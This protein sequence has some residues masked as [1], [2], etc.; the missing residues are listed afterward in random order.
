[1]LAGGARRQRGGE[2]ASELGNFSP[3]IQFSPPAG[4]SFVGPE[5]AFPTRSDGRIKFVNPMHIKRLQQ[6]GCPRKPEL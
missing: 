2:P 3:V 4:L 5:Q 1:L 6:G